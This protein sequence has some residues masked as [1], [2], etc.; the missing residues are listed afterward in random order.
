MVSTMD[1]GVSLE[2]FY[3]FLGEFTAFFGEME[4]FEQHKL[5]VLLSGSIQDIEHAMATAQANAK[6][7]E[8]LEN[9]RVALQKQAGL[10]GLTLRELTET[11]T[12]ERREQ[13][14]R[15]LH[16]L[17]T[18]VANIRFYNDKSMKVAEGNL[19]KT[20]HAPYIGEATGYGTHKSDGQDAARPSMLETKA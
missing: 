20:P 10:E 17:N 2:K 19:R 15:D 6:Q 12:D 3:S 11:A 5:G 13:L 18:H 9:K 16:R 14:S 1:K 7:L 8:N 4:Q